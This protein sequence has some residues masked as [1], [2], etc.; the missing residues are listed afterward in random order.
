MAYLN[1]AERQQLLDQLIT[2]D[3]KKARGKLRRLDPKSRVVVFR[4]NQN[5]GEWHTRY[6]LP[7]LGT[8]VILVESRLTPAAT[9]DQRLSD[10]YDLVRVIVEP[11][12]DNRT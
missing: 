4:N 3:F 1:E 2:M 7:G 9:P 6:E 12:P 5:T 11:L 8:R 10:D